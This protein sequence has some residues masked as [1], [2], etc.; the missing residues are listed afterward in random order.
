[1]ELVNAVFHQGLEHQFGYDAETLE[2][3]LRNAGLENV[4]QQVFG[5]SADPVMRLD[6]PER[7]EES[8]YMEA[9]K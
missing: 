2:F 9:V 4:T 6:L 5:R 1:M 7:A 8:L 3:V